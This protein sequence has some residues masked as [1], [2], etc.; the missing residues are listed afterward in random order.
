[1][2][3]RSRLLSLFLSLSVC[4]PLFGLLVHSGHFKGSLYTNSYRLRG[5][6]AFRWSPNDRNSLEAIEKHLFGHDVW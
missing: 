2:H 4:P 3:S 5:K 1:M 6:I